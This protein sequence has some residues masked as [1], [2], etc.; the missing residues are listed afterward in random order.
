MAHIPSKQFQPMQ[1]A[2]MSIS[3][4]RTLTTD[5]S[6]QVLIESMQAASH[7]LAERAL[8]LS[9]LQ[10]MD[11]SLAAQQ[12]GGTGLQAGSG[13]GVEPRPDLSAGVVYPM[14]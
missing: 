11:W 13:G 8:W 4:S 1:V 2:V 7:Q 12:R 14:V 5:T 6:G 10:Q 3:D 9:S